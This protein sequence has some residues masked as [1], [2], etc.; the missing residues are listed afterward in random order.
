MELKVNS[1][2]M[3]DKCYGKEN[4]S[5]ETA[6]SKS[7]DERQMQMQEGKVDTVKVLDA[8]LIV[9]ESSGTESEKHNTSSRSGNE[10][11][12][13]NADIRPV[14]DKEPMVEVQ[15]TAENNVIANG[16]QH[17]QQPEF[18]NEGRVDHDAEQCQVKSP[19]L[20]ARLFKKKDMVEKS[21]MN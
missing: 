12:A 4:R 20:D 11:Y 9:M 5:S 2:V 17:A 3:E 10:T 18:N 21:K 1:I 14:N 16:Q 15:L 6:F 13:E 8:S 7:V 19:L